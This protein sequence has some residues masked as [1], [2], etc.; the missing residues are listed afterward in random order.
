MLWACQSL[1]FQRL[2][3]GQAAGAAVAAVAAVTGMVEAAEKATVVLIMHPL[4]EP[5]AAAPTLAGAPSAALGALNTVACVTASG[6]GACACC[7]TGSGLS[8]VGASRG[9]GWP[10]PPDTVCAN[11]RSTGVLLPPGLL[12]LLPP[13]SSLQLP[14]SSLLLPPLESLIAAPF[15]PS[16]PIP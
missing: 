11:S 2:V 6:A 7:P 15:P 5:A 8:W 1:S 9:S 10:L 4:L 16:S 14:P 13:L 12:S 3:G